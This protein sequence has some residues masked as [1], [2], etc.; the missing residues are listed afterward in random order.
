MRKLVWFATIAAI[1][2]WS[3]VAWA[4]HWL[5]GFGGTAL[6]S[7]ADALPVDPLAVEWIWWLST[8]GTSVGEWIVIAVWALGSLAIV[9]LGFV[10][11]KFAAAGKLNN[12]RSRMKY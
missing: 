8:I 2:V 4:A 9:T 11:A 6:S 10:G 12:F 5:L 3:L 7:N 1:A